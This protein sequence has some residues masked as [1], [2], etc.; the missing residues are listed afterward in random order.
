MTEKLFKLG[1]SYQL[2]SLS[3]GL[4]YN[5]KTG[6]AMLLFRDCLG[7][8]QLVLSSWCVLHHI[9]CSCLFSLPPFFGGFCLL[10]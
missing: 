5:S 6:T 1:Q 7:I 10:I 3:L 4:C 2:D 9:S 8:D